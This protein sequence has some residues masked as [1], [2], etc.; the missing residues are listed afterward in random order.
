[1]NVTKTTLSVSEVGDLAVEQVVKVEG[2]VVGVVHEG[3]KND[4]EM[5]LKDVSNDTLIAVRH[6]PDATYPDFVYK[7]GDRIVFDAIVRKDISNSTCYKEKKYLN[8]IIQNNLF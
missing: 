6:I 8:F 5:I 4:T 2:I 7:K 3:L 1:M